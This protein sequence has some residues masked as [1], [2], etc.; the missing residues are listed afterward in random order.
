MKPPVEAP[1]SSAR[2]PAGSTPKASSA[3]ASLIPPRETNAGRSATSSVGVVGHQLARLAG[4]A[5]RPR[6]RRPPSPPRPPASGVSNSPRSASSVSSRRFGIGG[7]VPARRARVTDVTHQPSR[8]VASNAAMTIARL[9]SP[10]LRSGLL[11]AAGTALIAVPFAAR[12]DAA[13]IVTGVPIGVLVVA[14]ALAGTATERPRH[15]AGLRPGR[16]RPRLALGLLLVAVRVRARRRAS[17]RRCCS[18]PPASARWSSPRSRATARAPPLET[19]SRVHIASLLPQETA[20]L[21]RGRFRFG[22]LR[23]WPADGREHLRDP[24]ALDR[25]DRRSAG[26]TTT[27]PTWPP[28][29]RPSR[30]CGSRP[31]RQGRPARS[32]TPSS[33]C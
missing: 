25:F 28:P 15:A 29:R 31:A 19:S 33:C 17:A 30:R 5:V 14:L 21:R 12:T 27:A 13:A 10:A 4:R 24:S 16:L 20:P 32:S 22:H 2:R 26:S 11:M 23:D 1:T 6:A 3:L 8:G 18:R 9:I 7:R